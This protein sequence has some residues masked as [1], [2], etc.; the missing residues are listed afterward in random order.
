ML[1]IVF[2]DSFSSFFGRMVWVDIYG[3]IKKE[4]EKPEADNVNL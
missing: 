2:A 4:E 1:K 3:L